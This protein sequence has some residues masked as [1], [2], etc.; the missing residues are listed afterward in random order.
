[1]VSF[2]P[3]MR[4]SIDECL[5]HPFF[6]KIRRPIFET[7]SQKVINIEAIDSETAEAPPSMTLLKNIIREEVEFFRQ[8]R[9]EEGS[10]HLMK[11]FT[12]SKQ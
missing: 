4:P 7:P 11:P 10:Q 1:M 9:K 5:E 6:D 8:K 2:N 12:P 3:Y